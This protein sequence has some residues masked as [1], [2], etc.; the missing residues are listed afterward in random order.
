MSLITVQQ[1][2]ARIYTDNKL[3]DDFLTNPDVVG[4][5]LKLNCI[6]IQQLS[7]LSNKEVNMYA[8]SL[9]YK[10]LGEIRKL[11]PLTN[12]VLGNELNKLFFQ[13]AETYL[14]SK[15]NKHL[16]DA[17]Q[18]T[19]FILNTDIQPQW[20]LDIVRYESL[21]LKTINNQ[22]LIFAGCFNY[23][24]DIL[25][26]SLQGADF[27]PKLESKANITIWFRLTPKH[28]WHSLTIP[29]IDMQLKRSNK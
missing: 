7:K 21:W 29:S 15:N 4:R 22:K 28:N 24:I 13:F 20:I 2:L 17:V 10:R 5:T 9:K 14:P 26:R 16:Q 27:A 18:L 23:P 3:R 12:K 19:K 1:A 8:S 6:E 25:V 11:L